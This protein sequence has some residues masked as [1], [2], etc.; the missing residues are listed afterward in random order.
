VL[1]LLDFE[2]EVGSQSPEAIPGAFSVD[3]S[4]LRKSPRI[5]IPDDVEV[6]LYS[7]SGG[8]IVSARAAMALQ[9]IGVEKVWVLEG[10]LKAWREHGFPV[11]QSPEVPEIAAERVG[12]KLPLHELFET[13][14]QA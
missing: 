12:V 4:I 10:G 11:A 7:S 1:D 14:A 3:P 8:D 9:R 5:S 13:G 6:I 2:D